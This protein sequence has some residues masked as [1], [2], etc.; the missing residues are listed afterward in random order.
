MNM[1]DDLIFQGQDKEAACDMLIG[2]HLQDHHL[3][4]CIFQ[5]MKYEV[6]DI[7]QVKRYQDL[8]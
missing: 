8:N 3:E 1:V 2:M 6:E 4:Y 7:R 5:N